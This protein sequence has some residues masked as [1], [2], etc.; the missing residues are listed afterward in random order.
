MAS[1]DEDDYLTMAI[2]DPAASRTSKHETLT[3][4]RKRLAREAEIRANPKSKAELAAEAKRKRE[5]GLQK[6][7][8]GQNGATSKGAAMMAK[9]GY[10]PGTALGKADSTGTRLLEPLGIS[11]REG[12]G[13]IG[14]D[15]EKKRK[16]REGFAEREGEEKKRKV[17]AEEYRE[18]VAREREETRKEGQVWGA[19]KVAEKLEEEG[20]T[21]EL[22]KDVAGEVVSRKQKKRLH[23]INL[24]WRGLVKQ[25]EV[26]E[27]DRRMRYDLH[28]SL[29]TRADYNDPE[30]EDDKL[31]LG[32]KDAEEVDV[33]LDQE[34]EELDEFEQLEA[35]E[36]LDKLVAH[37]RERWKYCFWCKYRYPDEEM[38]GCPG[39]K[40]EDHD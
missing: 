21:E 28:Q 40:E 27:R 34:D 39:T 20:E 22:G 8:L 14:A 11:E 26:N 1:S 36:K 10:K 3:E 31:A 38:E 5:E 35:S 25:R 13:G 12:R 7:L 33:E 2:P 15:A 17:D 32:K 23:D 29:S 19:M 6:N 18:R 24:L 30:E 37:L 4:R 16:I 9:L